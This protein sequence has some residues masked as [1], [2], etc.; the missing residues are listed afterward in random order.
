M[1]SP[2][3]SIMASLGFTGG[4]GGGG[5]SGTPGVVGGSNMSFEAF[6]RSLGIDPNNMSPEMRDQLLSMFM[7]MKMQN[8]QRDQRQQDALQMPSGYTN[9]GNRGRGW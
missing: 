5:M 2:I 6:A 4:T 7:Q 9:V 8:N 3:T 1:P